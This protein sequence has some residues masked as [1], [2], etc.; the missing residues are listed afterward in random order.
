[1]TYKIEKWDMNARKC[2]A[3]YGGGYTEDDV[4]SIMKGQGYKK[5]D[6]ISSDFETAYNRKGSRYVYFA[7][8]ETELVKQLE[9]IA[10]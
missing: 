6:L 5:Y 7:T 10:E 9:I 8:Q 3:N 4:K 2:V 1:M